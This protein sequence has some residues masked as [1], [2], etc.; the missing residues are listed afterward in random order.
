M[1]RTMM[2]VLTR[3][4]TD[5][6]VISGTPTVRHSGDSL[7][8]K[9]EREGKG[10]GKG[11]GKEEGGAGGRGGEQ[12]GSRGGSRGGAGGEQRGSRGGKGVDE[13]KRRSPGMWDLERE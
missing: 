13:S 9:K 12:R 2:G 10:E 11:E 4:T 7:T 8:E 5:M 3:V 1:I 6:S